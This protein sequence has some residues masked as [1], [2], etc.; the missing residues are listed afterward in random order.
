MNDRANLKTGFLDNGAIELETYSNLK[1][2]RGA[3]RIARERFGMP[4]EGFVKLPVEA[5][6]LQKL[7]DALSAN[8]V[9]I[10]ADINSSDRM[11]GHS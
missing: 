4:M 1:P 7:A 5:D 6:D 11:P 10:V 2:D 9:E 3:V 8:E